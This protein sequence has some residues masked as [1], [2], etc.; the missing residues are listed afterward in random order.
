MTLNQV[1]NRRAMALQKHKFV[2]VAGRVK[3]VPV[4]CAA[5][6]EPIR[7]RNLRAVL[8]IP[9]VELFYNRGRVRTLVPAGEFA[10]YGNRERLDVRV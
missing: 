7:T 8:T 2:K 9:L 3:P 4:I 5:P 1:G 6:V 10:C